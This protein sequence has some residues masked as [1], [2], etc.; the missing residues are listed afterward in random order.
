MKV[1]R[2]INAPAWVL[3]CDNGEGNGCL[4]HAGFEYR[5]PCMS[6]LE[7]KVVLAVID[8]KKTE[9]G[10]SFVTFLLIYSE[11]EGSC[12]FAA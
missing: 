3:Q 6:P 8:L 10:L 7:F 5:R 9:L 11:S 1:Y 2:L 4:H 12:A